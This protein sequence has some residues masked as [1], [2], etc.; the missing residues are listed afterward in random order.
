MKFLTFD[1]VGSTSD[2]AKNLIKEGEV[3]P[4][5]VLAKKQTSGRGRSGKSWLSPEGN[6]YLSVVLSKEHFKDNN[7][8]ALPLAVGLSLCE[9]FERKFKLRLTLKW[10][11]IFFLL[12]KN[13][14]GF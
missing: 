12:E 3:P 2:I 8:S 6:I 14:L 9:F 4:L 10:L 11:M 1:E 7:P 13:L 5:T